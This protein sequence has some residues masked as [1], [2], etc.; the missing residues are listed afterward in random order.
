MR[1]LALSSLRTRA[2]SFVAYFL[3]VFFGTVLI[4]AFATLSSA[5]TGDVGVADA[6]R[7]RLMGTIVGGWG[8]VIVLFSLAST[9]TL[10]VGQRTAETSLL[11]SVGA[12]PKQVRRLVLTESTLVTFAAV[13][14]GAAPAWTVGIERCD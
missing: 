9:L 7:L 12:T 2:S 4:G 6:E 3:S 13:V 14:L 8:T 1:H 11:R 5:G 10:I